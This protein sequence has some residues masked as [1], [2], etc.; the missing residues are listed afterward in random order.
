[1]LLY[2][3]C[4]RDTGVVCQDDKG[5]GGETQP[6]RKQGFLYR[7]GRGLMA[8]VG[9]IGSCEGRNGKTRIRSQPCVLERS[10]FLERR[11]PETAVSAELTA[12][13]APSHGLAC[14]SSTLMP[15]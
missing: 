5:V 12:S 4:Y 7:A 10:R 15:K 1:M 6:Q 8:G 11:R 9:L 13:A 3:Q 14:L 2:L